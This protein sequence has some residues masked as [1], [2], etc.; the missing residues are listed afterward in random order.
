[1]YKHILVPI[2]G[3]TTSK[4][5]LAEAIRLAKL[6]GGRL[7]LVHVVDELSVAMAMGFSTGYV[8]DWFDSLRA[9][10]QRLLE[11]A[12][13]EA[14]HA[15]VEADTLLHDGFAQPVHELLAADA[16]A[17]PAEL[18][19]I[20]THGRRGVRRMVIGSTAEQIL[21][22]APVPVLLVRAPAEVEYPA[23]AQASAGEAAKAA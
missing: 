4:Q 10:G 3:S 17:W 8:G 12:E 19:V 13:L 23:A 15:G 21:R 2:D 16:R 9:L 11:E 14:R 7:R 20:G 6:T 5:G 18:I 1:M 22:Y